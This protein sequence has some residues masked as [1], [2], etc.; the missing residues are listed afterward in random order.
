[1]GSSIEEVVQLNE[2]SLKP[3]VTQ[4]QTDS[5][6]TT[7]PI[8]DPDDAEF[9]AAFNS[10]Y[11]TVVGALLT[12]T[13]RLVKLSRQLSLFGEEKKED[14]EEKIDEKNVESDGE[15][16]E[17]DENGGDDGDDEN[18]DVDS[19]DDLDDVNLIG[20]EDYYISIR[21]A[22]LVKPEIEKHFHSL[23]LCAFK[24]MTKES[25]AWISAR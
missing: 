6:T 21:D 1:M 16:G 22:L 11:E 20:M 13:Q 4:S 17:G 10:Q 14:V 8:S 15:D 25:N 23:H 7:D 24:H 9:V 5:P 19:S 12:G 3:I 18:D 2:S